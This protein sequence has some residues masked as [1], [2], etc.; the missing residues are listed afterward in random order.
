MSVELWR[1]ETAG[2]F[3][4]GGLSFDFGGL[5]FDFGGLSDVVKP[6][7]QG[8]S[9][10]DGLSY[11]VSRAPHMGG[12]GGQWCNGMNGIDQWGSGN[13]EGLEG[14]AFA[15]LVRASSHDLMPHTHAGYLQGALEGTAGVQDGRLCFQE[16]ES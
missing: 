13:V 9:R 8:T 4:L 1:D 10:I 3:D 11:G 6:C 12:S 15:G 2:R 14:I 7:E 16:G 5:S